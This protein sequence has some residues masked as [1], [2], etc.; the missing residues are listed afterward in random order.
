MVDLLPNHS[1]VSGR[2]VMNTQL[3]VSHSV[4]LEL[5]DDITNKS[6]VSTK[7]KEQIEN[8]LK[9]QAKMNILSEKMAR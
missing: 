5:A 7:T 8:E 4:D 6:Y 2:G 9:S 1:I 3:S